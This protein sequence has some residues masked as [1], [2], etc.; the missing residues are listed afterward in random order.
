M[1][2]FEELKTSLSSKLTL[3]GRYS[4][5]AEK[6]YPDIDSDL[7]F[8]LIQAALFSE[9]GISIKELADCLGI[10]YQTLKKR[11]DAVRE[12]NLL[13]DKKQGRQK[14]YELDIS[15]LDKEI[16]SDN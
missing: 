5:I 13:V 7:L 15:L 10:T 3:W 16:I 2:I 12:K 8:V 4:E 9:T 14:Y 1:C 6:N 11:L